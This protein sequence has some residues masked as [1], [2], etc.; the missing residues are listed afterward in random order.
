MNLRT[1]TLTDITALTKLM[2]LAMRGSGKAF[3]SEEDL[4]QLATYVAIPDPD[5]I[6]DGTYFV[7]EIEGEL[8]GAGG[9]SKRNL[10]CACEDTC[11]A[12]T[13]TWSNPT[14][15]SAKIRAFFV[16]P[17]HTRKGIGRQILN[18]SELAAQ[19]AGFHHAELMALLPG[20][21]L[22]SAAGYLVTAR[23]DIVLPNGHR[24]ACER[25]VK[26]LGSYVALPS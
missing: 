19:A 9:W 7:V 26:Q 18:A 6:G 12:A 23:E 15:D 16:H 20:V 21:P 5:I 13:E 1:A 25:M 24:I 3:Y 17:G 2:P 14:T 11:E 10:L 8:V 4:E 22:Y